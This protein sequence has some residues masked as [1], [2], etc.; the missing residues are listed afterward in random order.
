[1][2][3]YL[4]DHGGPR[5][6]THGDYRLDNLLIHPTTGE[7]AVVDWQ[8]CTV[9]NPMADVAYFIGAG[10]LPRDRREHEQDLVHTYLH[11]LTAAGVDQVDDDAAW[12]D[13][14]RGTWAGLV[15]AVGASMVVERT[16]RGDQMFLA[17]A[18]R[19]AAHAVDLD[20]A[21]LLG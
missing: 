14:R 16:D 6:V 13:Y 19:H 1:L 2:G 4:A 3:G 12:T 9:G 10:L 18:S 17:M 15:M 21:A 8:T 20:A 11:D 5:T 7:V